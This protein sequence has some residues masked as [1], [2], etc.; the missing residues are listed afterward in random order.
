MPP[1]A[2]SA[3]TGNY[4]GYNPGQR[5]TKLPSLKL[6]HSVGSRGKLSF[7]WSTTGTDSAFS[8]PNGN[9]DGLPEQI[10][11][12]R[13]TW[14][15]SLTERLNYD[16]TL[17]PTLLLHLGAGYS[18]IHFFDQSPFNHDGQTFNCSAL[19]LVG[20]Q[21]ALN[22]PT[23]GSTLA[24]SSGAATTTGSTLGGMQ[25]MGN[26]Q[27]HTDTYTFRPSFNT[28]LT[29][30]HGNH[31]VKGGGEVWFQGALTAP[32]TGVTL[33]FSHLRGSKHLFGCRQWRQWVASKPFHQ[34]R[35]RVPVR[36]LFVGRREPRQPDGSQQCPHGKAA[37]GPVHPGFLEGNPQALR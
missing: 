24:T 28:N 4:P 20:C 32:P 15:H 14:I 19:G 3:L 22:F 11:I 35:H 25:Q 16:H 29:W 12:A 37:V 1:P 7:Y 5:V 9:A 8:T 34:R 27:A 23:I 33:C 6:D 18:R 2:S 36:E 30:I 10:S 31:T 17:T 26:A 21:G 13:G